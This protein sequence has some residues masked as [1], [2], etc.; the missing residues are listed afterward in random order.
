M[1][2]K[3]IRFAT[4]SLEG[5]ISVAISIWNQLNEV[6]PLIYNEDDFLKHKVKAEIQN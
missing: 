6:I 2:G 5:I 3:V 4:E 1:I